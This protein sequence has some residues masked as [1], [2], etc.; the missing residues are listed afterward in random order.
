MALSL[1]ERIAAFSRRPSHFLSGTTAEAFLADLLRELRDDR[2]SFNDKVMFNIRVKME[3]YTFK[4]TVD[5]PIRDKMF[6]D[7]N[8]IAQL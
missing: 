1:T 8:R 7:Y 6:Q 4:C 3:A 2:L 5:A